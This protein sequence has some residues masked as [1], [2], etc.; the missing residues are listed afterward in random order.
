MND[1]HRQPDLSRN[2]IIHPT[3]GHPARRLDLVVCNGPC[4][5]IA[6]WERYSRPMDN[7]IKYSD[8]F[9]VKQRDQ[10]L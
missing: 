1:E 5:R 8:A 6:D 9:R 4:R 3:K 7:T 2:L 10:Y